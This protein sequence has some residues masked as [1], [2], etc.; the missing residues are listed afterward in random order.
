MSA[1]A[2]S[3]GISWTSLAI[4]SAERPAS[5]VA[6]RL[7]AEFA[8]ALHRQPRLAFDQ[9]A[10]GRRRVRRRAARRRSGARSA[11]CC[12]CRRF[13]RL[14]VAPIRSRRRTESRTTSILR[15]GAMT[16]AKARS[17][18]PPKGN[19]RQRLRRPPRPS[20]S[21]GRCRPASARRRASPPSPSRAGRDTP[22]CSKKRFELS[23]RRRADGLDHRAALAEQDRL[24]RLALDE[25]RAVQ[26]SAGRRACPAPRTGRRRRR[27]VNG[28]SSCVWR[29]TCSRTSS[30]AKK[31][32]GWSV[33]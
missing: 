17:A 15:C 22:S 13:S 18:Q 28:S 24:L 12:F 32:S 26:A 3:D 27:C 5:S 19:T 8:D 7:G 25:D 1:A 29:S 9:D 11:G 30:A 31:R 14:A 2:S 33:R 6:P 23:A 21:A 20:I 10:E 4:S 16:C